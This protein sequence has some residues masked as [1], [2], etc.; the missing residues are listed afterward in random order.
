MLVICWKVLWALVPLRLCLLVDFDAQS[1]ALQVAVE[2]D[3]STD[4]SR[5]EDRLSTVSLS[6]AGCSSGHSDRSCCLLGGMFIV[7]IK[8]I[9]LLLPVVGIVLFLVLCRLFRAEFWVVIFAL[10]A[11][12][13]VHLG[14]GNL[15][16]VR[17]AGRLLDNNLGARPFELLQDGDLL[18]LIHRMLFLK[19]F[20]TVKI[21]KNK[22]HAGEGTVLQGRVRNLDRL[23]N[24]ALQILGG[25]GFLF[26]L[27]MLAGISS[28]FVAG[29]VLLFYIFMVFLLPLLGRL[30]IM[31]M[32]VVLRQT[33]LFGLLVLCL[34]NAGMLMLCVTLPFCQVRLIFGVGGFLLL[35]VVSLL[36]MSGFGIILS[37]LVKMSASWAPCI[38]RLVLWILVLGVFLLLNCS[39]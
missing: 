3:V 28:E 18:C 37:L 25:G 15:N 13:G 35:Q 22:G 4:G 17:H 34:K 9:G 24:K 39:I 31:M 32:M 12:C 36:R 10:Q 16:V 20:G 19:S 11:S 5:I 6:S 2:P 38:G 26:T 29:G 1:E 33:L 27:L 14:V 23:G 7:M 30:L 8:G 21:S